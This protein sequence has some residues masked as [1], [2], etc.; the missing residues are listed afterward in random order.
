MK[1]ASRAA[2]T[3]L[4]LLIVITIIGV[5]TSI[6]VLN[7]VGVRQRQELTLLADQAVAMLQQARSEVAAGKVRTEVASDGTETVIFLCEG[8]FFEVDSAPLMVS[9]DYDSETE[10]CDFT[11]FSTELYGLS[12]GNAHVDELSASYVVYTPPDGEAIFYD[13]NGN[14]LTENV[15][16]HFAH[17][18]LDLDLSI[19]VSAQTG[20]VT[21]SL[22]GDEEE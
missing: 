4:E 11:T 17:N 22:G 6:L 5:L 9:G 2:F 21:L 12:T 16:I 8:A 13:E 10:A 14:L 7:F 1:S 15:D 18:D 19:T 3:L 20:L